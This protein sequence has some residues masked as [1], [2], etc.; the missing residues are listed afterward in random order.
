MTEPEPILGFWRYIDGGVVGVSRVPGGFI[1]TVHQ[2]IQLERCVHKAGEVMWKIKRSDGDY[3]GTHLGWAVADDCSS[4]RVDQ[5]TQ[6]HISAEM[7]ETIEAQ[8]L[9]NKYV[10]QRQPSLPINGRAYFFKGS[11]YVRYNLE[12][13]DSDQTIAS[14]SLGWKQLPPLFQKDLDAVVNFGNGYAYFFKNDLCVRYDILT[15]S[16]VGPRKISDSWPAMP[17]DFRN[18]DFDAVVNW[19]NGYAY[20][21]KNDLYVRYDIRTDSVAG[22]QRVWDYWPALPADF[23][24]GGFD[25]AVNFGK[26][27]AY[28]FKNNLYVRYDIGADTASPHSGEI[29]KVWKMLPK[30]F[31]ENFDAVVNWNLVVQWEDI[32]GYQ[33]ILYVMDKLV[34][35]Y[36]YPVNGAAGLVGN[37]MHESYLIPSIIE[38]ATEQSPMRAKDFYDK[39]KEHSADEIMNRDA[40][41][42]EGPKLPGVGLAQWSYGDRRKGL[43]THKLTDTALGASVLFN[44]D[45][46]IDYAVQEL[47]TSFKIANDVLKRPNVTASDA[48]DE[49]LYEYERPKSILG[50]D[51]KRLP[52]KHPSVQAVFEERRPKAMHAASL[53][54]NAH[55]E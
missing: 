25:A 17:A 20:F 9:T 35:R 40:Q 32:P 15:D 3:R 34:R 7:S 4:K 6:W 26:G 52:R 43:F 55:P 30:G 23:R 47:S 41:A 5:S 31:R 28:F 12:T 42:R 37:F 33:R 45:A 18:G 19:G 54:R 50:P 49:V 51:G 36:R 13:N 53:Y 10:F 39:S 1:G 44:M 14:I 24:N 16:V 46:Q 11:N 21:F 38:G 48:C 2:E 27:Y 22:P 8:I 29:S